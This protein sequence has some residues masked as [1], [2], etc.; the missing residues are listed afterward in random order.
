MGHSSEMY[1][2]M[3]D[4]LMHTVNQANEGELSHLDAMI[5]LRKAKNELEKGLEII[6]EYETEKINEIASEADK[7][8]GGYMGYEIK[9]VN[10]RKTFSFAACE[11]VKEIDHLKKQAEEKY[12]QAF[13]GFQKG[14]VQTT[15]LVEDD[16]DSPLGWIDENGQVLP[17]PEVNI[18]KSFLTF[19]ETKK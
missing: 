6:K 9:A 16:P 5:E 7:Y 13:E 11:E 12:K 2:Q 14:V 19:K 8:P 10:G 17:F 1:I 18:G 15:R 3:Q 4:A